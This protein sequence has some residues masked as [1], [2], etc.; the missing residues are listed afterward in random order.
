MGKYPEIENQLRNRLAELRVR[1][2]KVE[3]NLR[4]THEPLEADFAEQ[5]TSV[6]NDEV[7]QAL[8]TAMRN[9]YNE[10]LAVLQRMELGSY[11]NC[12]SCGEPIAIPRLKAVP[13]ARECV[14]CANGA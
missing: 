9:E 11:G 3:G 1:V 12:M 6:E 2:D 14:K 5:A 7:L 4:H 13:F 10:I 8:D